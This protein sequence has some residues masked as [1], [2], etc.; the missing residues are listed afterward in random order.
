MKWND[1]LD[2]EVRLFKFYFFGEFFLELDIS[3]C[4]ITSYALG[5][6]FGN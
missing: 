2:K 4:N 3:A 1:S 5:A 6:L